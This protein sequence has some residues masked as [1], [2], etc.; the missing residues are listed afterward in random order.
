M[1]LRGTTVLAACA[2]AL[3]L[4]ASASAQDTTRTRTTSERRIRVQKSTG[5][6]AR[7][8]TTPA[9]VT[10][11]DSAR[12]ADSLMRADSLRADSIARADSIS[13][14]RADSVA[15]AD[16]IAA[17][18][19]A[20]ADSIAR[21][22]RARQDSIAAVEAIRRDS[23]ARADSIANEEQLRR[24]RMR[25]RYLFNGSGW[26]IGVSAG[27]AMPTGDFEALGYGKGFAV[28][29]PIGWHA[30]SSFLGA[31]LD[32]GYTQFDGETFT[33][34]GT[35][36]TPV[37]LNNSSPKVLSAALNLTARLPLNGSRSLNLYGVGGAGLYHFRSFGPTS[38]LGGFLGNDVLDPNDE[39]I[40]RTKNKVGTQFGAGIDFGVG[41]ASIFLE[42]RWVNVYAD[43]GDAVQFRDFF[44]DRSSNVRWVPI[45]LG[46]NFR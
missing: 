36:N 32:L 22:E 45:V 41:P 42:S 38:A 15:R 23:V 3:A 30:R 39:A 43:R 13:K 4:A 25:D 44:G 33:G 5:E 16:S 8:P 1:T 2:A 9:R 19:R 24:Q 29:V 46:I 6:V 35:G 31:R 18:E 20:R 17:I 37:T 27:G 12:M 21:I 26:Y 40:E 10:P 28:N 7:F 34:I 11:R 14:V